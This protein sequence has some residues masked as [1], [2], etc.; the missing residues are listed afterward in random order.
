MGGKEGRKEGKEEGRKG[1]ERLCFALAGVAQWIKHQPTDQRVTGLF[2]SQG[3]R[4][5][6]EPGPQ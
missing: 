6:C 5:A 2:P 1:K 3:T 4:L